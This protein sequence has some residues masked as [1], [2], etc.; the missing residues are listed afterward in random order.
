M[1]Y[2]FVFMF[3][4][5]LGFYVMLTEKK[6]I[7]MVIGLNIME[8]AIYFWVI[9]VNHR[10]GII[11]I[12]EAG[13][14]A[15]EVVNPLPQALILTGIVIGASTTAFLLT[16]VIEINKFSTSTDLDMLKGLRD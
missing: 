15:A 7:K 5:S 6:L 9:A 13:K 8:T 4:F 3:L 11:P 14:E 16:L 10:Q 2:N 12:L 1:V